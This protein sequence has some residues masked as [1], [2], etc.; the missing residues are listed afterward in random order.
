MG[1]V[2]SLVTPLLLHMIASQCT[3]VVFGGHLDSAGC[4]TIAAMAVLPF[5]IWMRYKDR[6]FWPGSCALPEEAS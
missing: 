2:L 5:G 1:S 3:A 6:W 4:T